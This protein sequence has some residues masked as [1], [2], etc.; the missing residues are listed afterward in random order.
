DVLLR[1][2]SIVGA[3]VTRDALAPRET[4]SKMSDSGYDFFPIDA[5]VCLGLPHFMAEEIDTPRGVRTIAEALVAVYFDLAKIGAAW[6]RL[7]SARERDAL[8]RAGVLRYLEEAVAAVGGT[9]AFRAMLDTIE[10]VERQPPHTDDEIVDGARFVDL[11]LPERQS[12]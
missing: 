4:Q 2:S 1:L 8:D 12:A 9:S 11:L 7:S 5:D 10:A 6:L 3:V